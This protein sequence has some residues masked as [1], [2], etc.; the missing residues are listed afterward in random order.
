MESNQAVDPPSIDY[1]GLSIINHDYEN[2]SFNDRFKVRDSS[3]ADAGH[4]K[5]FFKS[6]YFGDNV[7]YLLDKSK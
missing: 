4:I 2:I 6:T 3:L 7:K 1:F 5:K